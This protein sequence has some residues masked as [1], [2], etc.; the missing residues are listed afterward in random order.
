MPVIQSVF[1]DLYETLAHWEPARENLQAAACA[2]FGIQVDSQSL[3][4][5]YAVADALL[6]QQNT[7]YPVR[8]MVREDRLLF[9]AEY[10]R[11][12]LRE[13]GARVSRELAGRIFKQLTQFTY[14]LVLYDDVLPVLAKLSA[15]GIILG[16]I[17][18]YSR[19]I[20]V[21]TQ[22]LGLD[23]YLDFA[24][25]SKEVGAEKPHPQIFQFALGKS[26]TEPRQTL[27]VGDQYDS[28]VQGALNMGINPLLLDRDDL[29]A[30]YKDVR[31]I[32]TLFEVPES[33]RILGN[34]T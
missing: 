22:R 19:D 1:F 32:R 26:M 17:S 7:K 28:D 15:E 9:F 16:V 34:Q 10:E 29:F 13:A 30:R 18:N 4:R 23:A 5:G 24:V 2:E 3:I 20:H 25:T 33:I 21:L 12:L 31:R 8:N 11:V 6:A 27:H 14:D